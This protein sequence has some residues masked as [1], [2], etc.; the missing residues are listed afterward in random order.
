MS[1]LHKIIQTIGKHTKLRKSHGHCNPTPQ[2]LPP[3]VMLVSRKE[4]LDLFP[5]ICKHDPH[6][7]VDLYD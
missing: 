6:H 1:L 7:P 2:I 5:F 4:G 3:E